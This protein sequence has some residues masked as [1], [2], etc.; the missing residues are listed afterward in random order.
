MLVARTGVVLA[1]VL[2]LLG[3]LIS[4]YP[5]AEVGWFGFAAAVALTGLFSPTRRLRLVAV[6]LAVLLAVFA[7]G[8]HVRG[9][10]HRELLSQQP[11]LLDLPSEQAP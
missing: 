5:G 6:I 2:G 9:R 1:A 8:G 10:Q 7:W 11:K 3:Q 4:F